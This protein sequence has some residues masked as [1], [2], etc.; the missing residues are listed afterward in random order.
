MMQFLKG[1]PLIVP[2]LNSVVQ[3]PFEID[4]VNLPLVADVVA[5]HPLTIAQRFLHFRRGNTA[6]APFSFS[7]PLPLRSRLLAPD[8]GES[9]RRRTSRFA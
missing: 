3:N 1:I 2:W 7:R 5:P 9:S 8:A 4:P 6:R